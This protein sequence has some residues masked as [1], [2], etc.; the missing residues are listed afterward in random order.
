MADGASR[1]RMASSDLGASLAAM[2]IA[3]SAAK[4]D[5]GDS[6]TI[7]MPIVSPPTP[8]PSPRPIS[9]TL[10]SAPADVAHASRLEFAALKSVG[11]TA[12]QQY[13]A[14]L[15]ADC[16]PAELLFVSTTIA[17]LLKRDFLRDL[18]IELSLHILD[19]VDDAR[20]LARASRVSRFWNSLMKDEATWRRMCVQAKFEDRLYPKSLSKFQDGISSSSRSS[21]SN[22]SLMDGK[23]RVVLQ[24]IPTELPPEFSYR[25]HFAYCY[26]T[27]EQT[28]SVVMLS[29]SQC[30]FSDELAY[31]G[32]PT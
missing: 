13:L 11:P 2:T 27:S 18:P 24:E 8:A 23:A 9:S 30:P 16:S 1:S 21:E 7:Y 28:F 12:R 15:L 26:K 29:R 3:E 10:S 31:K 20:T 25:R 19:Y 22:V 14:A 6:S 4:V 17:P 32:P 5:P